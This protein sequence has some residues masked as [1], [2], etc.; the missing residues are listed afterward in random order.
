MLRGWRRSSRRTTSPIR[1]SRQVAFNSALHYR[2]KFRAPPRKFAKFAQYRKL[3]RT[4]VILPKMRRLFRTLVLSFFSANCYRDVA[5]RWRGCGFAYLAFITAIFAAVLLPRAVSVQHDFD[6]VTHGVFL[7]ILRQIPRFRIEQGR[8]S[9]FAPM[10]YSV[11]EPA[12]GAEVMVFDTTGKINTLV[13]RTACVLVT[14]RALQIRLDPGERPRELDLSFVSDFDGDPEPLAVWLEKR[15][16]YFILFGFFV[17]TVFSLFSLTIIA[18]SS[19]TL[20]L[21]LMEISSRIDLSLTATTRLAAVA[22]TP[23]RLLIL[24]FEVAGYPLPIIFGW[25]L[26]AMLTT[27]YL[28]FGLW[29]NLPGRGSDQ[30]A[31]TDIVP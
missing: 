23:S 13:G 3:L 22:T 25:F 5:R 27:G 26:T 7:P 28:C 8:V 16:S 31:E 2:L 14:G 1:I 15:G 12:S 30:S 29:A 17:A 9:V 24:A 20:G 10:P 19:A 18:A 6:T 11:T 21:I 4:L